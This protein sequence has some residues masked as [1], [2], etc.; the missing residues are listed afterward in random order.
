MR[1]ML[2]IAAVATVV[3]SPAWAWDPSG[4][5]EPW[6]APSPHDEWDVLATGY[7]GASA[8]IADATDPDVVWIALGDRT[9]RHTLSGGATAEWP[10]LPADG[11][12]VPAAGAPLVATPTALF[13]A[14]PDGSW[15]TIADGFDTLGT[16]IVDDTAGQVCAYEGDPSLRL[17]CAPWSPGADGGV[18][19]LGDAV[20]LA[21]P[22]A[23]GRGVAVSDGGVWFG[24]GGAEPRQTWWVSLRGSGLTP[25][26]S[27]R[28]W[29]AELVPVLDAGAVFVIAS[30]SSGGW[31]ERLDEATGVFE[32]LGYAPRGS[33]DLVHDDSTLWWRSPS[34]IWRLELD[35]GALPEAV[36]VE[37]EPVG[38]V[39]QQDRVVWLDRW[40]GEVLAVP[41]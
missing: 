2:T 25:W 21:D 9:V 26:A 40:R 27:S 30:S 31:I 41:R 7:A 32:R 1:R 20:V 23:E 4:D 39:V 36:A 33:R 12:L 22:V 16:V 28:F 5:L 13:V 29:S 3:A 18:G 10:P 8:M 11:R 19:E 35:A 38:L 34:T 6:T 37:T 24:E 14:A 17:W 15:Q